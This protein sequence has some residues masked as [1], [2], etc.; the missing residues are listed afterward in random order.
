MLAHV[1]HGDV[2]EAPLRRGAAEAL[3]IAAHGDSKHSK[4]IGKR[5]DELTGH[6]A[7]VA[8]LVRNFEKLLSLDKP[9]SGHQLLATVKLLSPTTI[10]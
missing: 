4:A 7:T 9:M 5:I 10:R 2:A 6:M 3:E 1:R 8:A